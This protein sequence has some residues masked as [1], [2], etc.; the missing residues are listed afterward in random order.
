MNILREI[1]QARHK[2]A[3]KNTPKKQTTYM[4]RVRLPTQ[5]KTKKCS[6]CG[7]SGTTIT[8]NNQKFVRCKDHIKEFNMRNESFP[9]IFKK[10]K[11]QE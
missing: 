7:K 9:V 11:P 10:A 4:T 2:N 1:A 5:A 3:K 8:V 6:I